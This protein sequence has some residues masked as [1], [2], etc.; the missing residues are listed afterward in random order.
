MSRCI[1]DVSVWQ[2]AQFGSPAPREFARHTQ[3]VAE[4]ELPPIADRQP[5]PAPDRRRYRPSPTANGYRPRTAAATA[6]RSTANRYR[7]R[8]AALAPDPAA[9]PPIAGRQT[10][11]GPRPPLPPPNPA[12]VPP[13]AVPPTVTGPGPPPLPPDPAA[14]P[15]D[16]AGAGPTGAGRTAPN[17]RPYYRPGSAKAPELLPAS[18]AVSAPVCA[19]PHRSHTSPNKP[20]HVSACSRRLG[21]AA[22]PIWLAG[23]TRVRKHTQ[24]VP[25][26]GD[27]AVHNTHPRAANGLYRSARGT[28]PA[29]SPQPV[30]RLGTG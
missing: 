23:T 5:L 25:R 2:Q 7:P 20:A 30:G 22:S 1:H 21:V 8:T 10:V 24:T 18:P 14:P 9:L 11:T 3:T 26:W 19:V 4:V 15:P 16:P 13:I 12:A 28:R 17:Y 27:C 29:A 6:H